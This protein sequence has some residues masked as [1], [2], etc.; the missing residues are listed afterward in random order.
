MRAQRGNCVEGLIG[1]EA[2]F[3]S[4]KGHPGSIVVWTW[5]MEAFLGNIEAFLEPWRLNME[6]I[7]AWLEP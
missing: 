7:A 1:Q 2:F 5:A 3:L 6:A 4:N